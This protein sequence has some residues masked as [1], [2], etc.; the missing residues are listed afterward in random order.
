MEKM[1]DSVR[2]KLERE[3]ALEEERQKERQARRDAKLAA[4]AWLENLGRP[5]DEFERFRIRDEP[6]A[7]K[8]GVC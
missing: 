3:A 5:R 4:I 7:K 1:V 2:E 6:S 8:P